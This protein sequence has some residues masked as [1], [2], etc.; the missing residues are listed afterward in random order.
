MS[1]DRSALLIARVLFKKLG[2][3][4][5]ISDGTLELYE[6]SVLLKPRWYTQSRGRIRREPETSGEDISFSEIIQITAMVKGLL[7]K[8]AEIRIQTEPDVIWE[9]R[10]NPKV[11][12]R[13]LAEFQAW[14]AKGSP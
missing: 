12:S 4:L 6:D 2:E 8:T 3:G 14:K 13:L 9:I 1:T 10:A 11:Y 7:L 5:D